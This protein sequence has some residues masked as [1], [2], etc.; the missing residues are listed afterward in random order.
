MLTFDQ[1]RI[2]MK[3]DAIIFVAGLIL[4]AFVSASCATKVSTAAQS[5]I[6]AHP[7]PRAQVDVTLETAIDGGR[8]LYIGVGGDIDGLVN[9]DLIVQSGT[10]VQVTLVNGDGISH[11]V[12][13]SDFNARTSI[14]TSRGSTAT[15]TFTIEEDRLGMF[16]YFCTMPGHR[17][18]GQEG[19]L[20]VASK[21]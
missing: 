16:S 9:P 1:G 12:F 11:D 8:M 3:K 19:R 5:S 4:Y 20:I 10:T 21:K 2:G 6:P 15:I 18:A 7:T 17:Q 13:F 14:V